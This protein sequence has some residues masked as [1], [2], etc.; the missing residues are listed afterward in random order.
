MPIYEFY[1]PDCHV[2]F[3]FFSRTLNTTKRPDCPHCRRA[4]LDRRFS[5]FAISKGRRE[6]EAGGEEGGGPDIDESRMDE[7]MEGLAR[8]TEGIDEDNP[9]QMAKVMRK[10]YEASGLPLGGRM[11]EAIR[12]MEAGEDPDKLEEELGDFL[13]EEPIPG[14][15][16][17]GN[18]LLRGLARKLR[19]PAVD[20][21]LYD[22]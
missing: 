3:N 21:T 12:R 4:R 19:A 10:L 22:L 6:P 9:R 1:C 11:E 8:E 15:G 2:I 5:R 16:Q 20:D 17:Q 18:P 13:D 7:I 14:E